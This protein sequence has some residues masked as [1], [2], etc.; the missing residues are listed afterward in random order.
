MGSVDV[1]SDGSMEAPP[2]P[3]PKRRRAVQRM[4][5][6]R[7][8]GPIS[9]YLGICCADG[10][11]KHIPVGPDVIGDPFDASSHFV[12]LPPGWAMEVFQHARFL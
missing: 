12:A 10:F 2:A 7:L 6:V 5:D 3:A 1:D 9:V 4:V 8:F 11:G